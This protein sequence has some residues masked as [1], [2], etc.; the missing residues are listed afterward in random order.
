MSDLAEHLGLRQTD[1]L[2]NWFAQAG[3][4]VKSSLHTQPQHGK[5]QNSHDTLAFARQRETT[6][7]YCLERE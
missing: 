5:A 2:N 4:R 6:T 7:L 3:W 1:D